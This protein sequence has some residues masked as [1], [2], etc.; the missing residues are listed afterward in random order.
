MALV[1]RGGSVKTI[2]REGIDASARIATD[3]SRI[4]NGCEEHFTSGHA[5][6]VHSRKQFAWGPKEQRV[7]TNTEEGFFSIVKR[8]LNGIYHS[9]SREHLHRYLA[10]FEF[11]YNNRA[12]T[13][14]E[15]TVA[16]IKASEGKR[17]VYR[18]TLTA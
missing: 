3:D 2:M 13:D 5:S 18:E 11:R 14:G 1:E 16:A 12:L 15:R 17:L 9:V 4:Y 7:H 10:E 6:V 8:G